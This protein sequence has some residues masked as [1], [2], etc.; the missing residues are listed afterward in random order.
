LNM[1][2]IDN[3]G[4]AID[5]SASGAL[6]LEAGQSVAL[7]RAEIDMQISTARAY[8]RSPAKAQKAMLE[9]VQLDAESAAE[10]MYA[11]P[12]D[13]KPITGPSIRFAEALKNSWGNNSS[14]S[15][16]TEINRAEG[17]VEAEGVFLDLETNVR[18]TFRTRRSIRGKSGRVYPERMILVTGNAAC[19]IAMREAIL[20]GVPKPVWRS[21]YALVQQTI[22][23]DIKTLGERRQRAVAAFAA[24]GVSAEKVFAR[25]EVAGIEDIG[26]DDLPELFA[27]FQS[28]KSGEATVED[29]FSAKA[30]NG[31]DGG[32]KNPLSDHEDGADAKKS[33]RDIGSPGDAKAE[34]GLA[35]HSPSSAERTVTKEPVTDREGFGSGAAGDVPI[36]GKDGD[37]RSSPSAPSEP[38]QKSE[39]VGARMG[40]GSADDGKGAGIAATVTAPEPV[41]DQQKPHQDAQDAPIDTWTADELADAE[42][43]GSAAYGN[44]MPRRAGERSVFKDPDQAPLLAAW[45]TGYDA[46]KAKG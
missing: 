16:L 9:L 26:L 17:Y 46:A 13:G 22:K 24:Y 21:S 3:D 7:A 33:S 8:P 1:P 44:G 20:K 5:E 11:L 37:G 41:K 34:G 35:P 6:M 25:L 12:V 29:Y 30:V 27:M 28:I 15:R 43:A 36:A 42:N 10:C 39:A 31:A 2:T 18:T 14:G 38:L 45:L 23:G 32:V 19:S 4:A 40:H